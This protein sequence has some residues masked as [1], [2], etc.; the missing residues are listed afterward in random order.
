LA[1]GCFS[2]LFF[3]KLTLNPSLGSK[4]GTFA[5]FFCSPFSFFQEK[6]GGGMSWFRN[7]PDSF[8]GSKR[9][10][11]AD[12]FL[13]NKRYRLLQLSSAPLL[14]FPREGGRGDELV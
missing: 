14:F 6:G 11:F 4:R 10:T 12:F 7:S 1:V 13:F 3:N 8:L 2:S 9:G 5:A